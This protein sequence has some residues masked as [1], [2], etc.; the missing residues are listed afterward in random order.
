[1]KSLLILTLIIHTSFAATLNVCTSGC[2]YSTAQ[3]AFNASNP[4]D[5]IILQS[6]QTLGP[7]IMPGNTH[8]LTFKSS[9]I[10]TYPRGYRM[11]RGNP[12]LAK[13]TGVTIGDTAG[14]V[15]LTGPGATITNQPGQV[16]QHHNLN[17]GDAVV[18][19]N[20]VWSAYNCASLNQPPYDSTTG[21]CS[22]DKVGKINIRNNTGFANGMQ[23]RFM[24]NPP[25]PIVANQLYYIVNFVQGGA[26]S[27]CGIAYPSCADSFQIAATS[28]GTPILVPQFNP[29]GTDF[30]IQIDPL[31]ALNGQTLYVV[32]VPTLTTLQLSATLGGPPITF[33]Q[34]GN[35]YDGSRINPGFSIIKS[36]PVHD[37][38]FDGIEIQPTSDYGV[39]YPFYVSSAIG[40]NQ[41]EH[42]TIR[43]LRSWVHAHDDQEDYPFCTVN[44]A[45][46]DIEV[47][48]SVIEGAYSTGNDT[49]NVGFISTGHVYIHDNEFPG[50]TE[51]I[52]SGGN[53]PWFGFVRNTTD[54]RVQR[55][56]FWK[57]LKWYTGITAVNLN[58]TQFAFVS[59]NG[60]ADCSTVASNPN[61]GLQCFAYE[62]S[63]SNPAEDVVSRTN[64]TANLAASTFTVTSP[65]ANG[66]CSNY[67]SVYG[68]GYIY[69]LNSQYHMDYNFGTATVS[70]PGEVVCTYT[71]SPSFPSASSRIGI[72]LPNASG[73]FDGGFYQ[74]FRNVWSKNH[75]E[76]KY[77]D[78]W[79]IEGNVFHRQDDCDA[80]STCQSIAIRFAAGIGGSG[81][82]E[83]VNYIVSSSNSLVQN[84]I[85]RM[86]SSGVNGASLSYAVNISAQGLIYE[87]AGFGAANNNTVQNNLFWDIGS[88][89]YSGFNDGLIVGSTANGWLIDHN[90]IAD[91]SSGFLASGDSNTWHSNVAVPYRM[92]AADNQCHPFNCTHP[93]STTNIGAQAVEQDFPLFTD[94]NGHSSWGSLVGSGSLTNSSLLN[95][96]LMNRSGF[97]YN[98]SIPTFY[99]SNT[100]LV[101][102]SDAM[103]GNVSPDPSLVFQM[104]NERNNATP[105]NGLNYR[106]SN[107]RLAPG[108]AA[109][110]PAYDSRAIGAD[111]DEIEAITGK[112]GVD[113]EQ[114]R[115]KFSDRVAR[116]IDA[117][118]TSAVLSY[119]P[120]GSSCTIEVW[121]NSSY[122]GAP[123]VNTT[124]RN[125]D[126]LAGRT[127]VTL[128]SLA[129][130]TTYYGKRWCSS[131]VDVFSFTTAPTT[132]TL[133]VQF[134]PPSGTAGCQ[135]EYG[136]TPALG[137]S[138]SSVTVANGSC[139]ITVP[140]AAY[141]RA[142]YLSSA[143]KVISSGNIQGRGL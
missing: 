48:W 65:S 6:G 126:T 127:L 3:G 31:P 99:P 96:I 86:L 22:A 81:A 106:T 138:L 33:T 84:N 85:F 38:T 34:A 69:L 89:E 39:Y 35:S 91:V 49:Q 107:F 110:Y 104:W 112:A 88:S 47:G 20:E 143:G 128:S 123:A 11:T 133:A 62:S 116:N 67:G 132:P 2:A 52:M 13:L 134:A 77:G 100:Y 50:A 18:V 41:G 130:G 76:S 108:I 58:S 56:Y 137:S 55:N 103:P 10:D 24:G 114:G 95:N 113:V 8:N 70:C 93:A 26:T 60:G 119:L 43:L 40:T 87:W 131:E 136:P 75:L 1:M 51:N 61:L 53:T 4:G 37:L 9:L 101:Q 23:I 71:S 120:N 142:D 82:G 46:R 140:A 83:A 66:A 74:E 118:A 29:S 98:S 139:T 97:V 17:V 102:S 42:Y 141:W 14:W 64:W 5:T 12:V 28:G 16:P 59:R 19:K 45:A 27:A 78:N 105:P 117:G 57:P 129:A 124:D 92:S 115:P 32:A 25:T 15:A 79:L 135:V 36:S 72:A 21:A 44:I 68:C 122:S 125:A 63:E 90:T 7:L 80:G 121:P 111:I 54:I 109:A 73:A 30:N 94:G